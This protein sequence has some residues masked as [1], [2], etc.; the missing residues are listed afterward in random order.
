MTNKRAKNVVEFIEVIAIESSNDNNSIYTEEL[1]E[2]NV[3][4]PIKKGKSWSRQKV[5]I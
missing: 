1:L 2:Y 5:A 3:K 4:T